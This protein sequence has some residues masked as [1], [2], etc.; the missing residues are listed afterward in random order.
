ML[1][2]G[3]DLSVAE[4]HNRTSPAKAQPRQ[5]TLT[6]TATRHHRCH[7]HRNPWGETGYD[8]LQYRRHLEARASSWPYMDYDLPKKSEQVIAALRRQ[9][10]EIQLAA[11]MLH[12]TQ[13]AE[14]RIA[15][16]HGQYDG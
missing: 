15:Q 8:C 4:R 16:E 2:T 9:L 1:L 6:R 13:Q 10:R 11:T 14:Q 3:T 5:V 7:R 12:T